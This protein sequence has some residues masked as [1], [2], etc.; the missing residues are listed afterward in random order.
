LPASVS[1][2][3]NLAVLLYFYVLIIVFCVLPL[4]GLDRSSEYSLR[5]Q[6]MTVNGSGPPTQ[7]IT[8]DTFAHDLDGNKSVLLIVSESADPLPS[9]LI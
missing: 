1:V 9:H 8:V 4:V 6:A 7:W 5:I 2:S 3:L